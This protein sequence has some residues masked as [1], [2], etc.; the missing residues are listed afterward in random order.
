M[1]PIKT[2][3]S[4]HRAVNLLAQVRWRDGVYCPCCRTDSRVVCERVDPS[5]SVY[6]VVKSSSRGLLMKHLTET[7]LDREI[8]DA[9]KADETRLVRRLCFVKNLYQGDT[10]KEAGNLS[11]RRPLLWVVYHDYQILRVRPERPS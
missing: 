9:Q 1:F 7:E 4:E 8:E 10:R 6:A 3:V 2:F 11:I 5:G